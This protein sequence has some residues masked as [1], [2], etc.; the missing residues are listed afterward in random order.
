MSRRTVALLLCAAAAGACASGGGWHTAPPGVLGCFPS[1]AFLGRFG[2]PAAPDTLVRGW[3][4]LDLRR[5]R[6]DLD[7]YTA[8]FFLPEDDGGDPTASS[9]VGTW[10]RHGDSLRVT[11]GSLTREVELRLAVEGDSLRG[12]G[13]QFS[14]EYMRDSTGAWIQLTHSWPVRAARGPCGRVPP[15]LERHSRTRQP[16][17]ILIPDTD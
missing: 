17:S 7:V 3:L 16:P 10:R 15:R 5:V 9:W 13:V 12:Q 4:V 2:D 6:P 14:D 11:A 1:R 8:R